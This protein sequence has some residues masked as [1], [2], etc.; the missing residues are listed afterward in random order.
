MNNA[1]NLERLTPGF[2]DQALESQQ[3]FRKLLSAMSYPGRIEKLDGTITPPYP[4]YMAS[5]AICLTLLDYET[6]LWSDLNPDGD[7]MTWIRF[8]T[9]CPLVEEPSKAGFALITKCDKLPPVS[10]FAAGSAESPELS[11]T[12]ILQLNGFAAGHSLK[13]AGPGIKTATVI[14]LKGPSDN[15]FQERSE[16]NRFPSGVDIIFTYRNKLSAI[17]RSIQITNGG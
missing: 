2:M 11:T 10:Q 7:A 8:H 16:C 4:L 12:L 14:N 17:P 9:G 5:G 3:V 15:F 1:I 13:L 6:P